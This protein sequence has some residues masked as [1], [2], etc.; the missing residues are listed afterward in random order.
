MV[1]IRS[2]IRRGCRSEGRVVDSWSEHVIFYI[3]AEYP[4]YGFAISATAVRLTK[5]L[6]FVLSASCYKA[7]AD[8]RIIH[9]I[10]HGYMGVH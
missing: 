7:C 6:I 10:T 8:I 2:S 5:D 4:D 1:E 9:T 3:E